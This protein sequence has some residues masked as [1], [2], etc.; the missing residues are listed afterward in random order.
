MTSIFNNKI[1]ILAQKSLDFRVK[2]HNLH[3][4]NIA[5]KDTPQYKAED[6]IFE[7]SLKKAFH[8]D[9]PGPLRK[10]RNIHFNG[11]QTMPLREV[12]AQ[13][14]LSS[15]PFPDFNGNTVD[16]DREMAKLAEN[17]LMYNASL[18]MLAHKFKGLK[19]AISQG[20]L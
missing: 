9:K 15:S 11:N 7:S 16:L 12:Q 14:I 13:R 5:N 20:T 17:Q 4:S 6:L 2:K 8:S 18:R 10:T 19:N 3:S 1:F